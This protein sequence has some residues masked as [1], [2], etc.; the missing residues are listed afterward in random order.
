M[1]P[2]FITK[3]AFTVVGIKLRHEDHDN[4]QEI[5]QLWGDFMPRGKEIAQMVTPPVM[6]GLMGN[7][8][9]ETDAFD[10]MAGV[11]VTAVENIPE[12]MERWD[13]PEQH[14]AV[15]ETTLA[16]LQESYDFICNTWPK[17]SGYVLTRGTEFELYDETF[18]GDAHQTFYIYTPVRKP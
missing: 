4:K 14:Y 6:Y 8:D 7:F 3:P 13:V 15:F 16:T 5:P 10:Y 1:Q 2:T 12:G 11:G 18:N 9:P 17:E